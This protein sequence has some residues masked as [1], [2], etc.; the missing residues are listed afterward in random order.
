MSKMLRKEG[1]TRGQRAT[2]IA[3]KAKRPLLLETIGIVTFGRMMVLES[4]VWIGLR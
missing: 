4:I 2:G 3:S 1:I